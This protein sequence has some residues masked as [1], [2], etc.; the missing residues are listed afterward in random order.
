MAQV[1]APRRQRGGG[2]EVLWVMR[3]KNGWKKKKEERGLFCDLLGIWERKLWVVW[4]AGHIKTPQI[5][6]FFSVCLCIC[7]YS[8]LSRNLNKK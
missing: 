7:T 5:L 3:E 1:P 4:N 8:S 2:V 6:F